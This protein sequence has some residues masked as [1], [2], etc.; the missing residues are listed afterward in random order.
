MFPIGH[1]FVSSKMIAPLVFL[2]SFCQRSCWDAIKRAI[3]GQPPIHPRVLAGAIQYGLI[4]RIRTSRALEEAIEVRNDFRRLVEDRRTDHTTI[5]KF[6]QKNSANLKNFFVRIALVARELGHLPLASLGFDGTRLRANNRKSG[7]RTPEELRKAKEE[8][9]AK[10]TELEAQAAAADAK[11]DQRLGKDSEH[12]LDKEL[13][14][15]A[16][17]QKRVDAALVELERLEQE[18]QKKPAKTNTC[19]RRSAVC[20]R[21]WGWSKLPPSRLSPSS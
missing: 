11:D 19:L 12:K 17:R 14:D 16:P 4:K 15:V 10:Y 9:A 20:K 3:K 2:L 6:R 5:C 21:G 18:G 13:A 1:R 8:L 7:T